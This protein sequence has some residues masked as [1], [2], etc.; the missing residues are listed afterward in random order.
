MNH[1]LA[2]LQTF[3][4]ND[5]ELT[6]QVRK[7]DITVWE[8]IESIPSGVDFPFVLLKNGGVESKEIFSYQKE[9]FLTARIYVV[10][11]TYRP[12]PDQIMDTNRGALVVAKHIVDLLEED[13]NHQFALVGFYTGS[14]PVQIHTI[15]GPFESEPFTPRGIT[16]G[17]TGKSTSRI[18]IDAR[19]YR[20]SI[21]EVQIA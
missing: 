21:R 16:T 5:Y 11:R 14:I 1:V 19:Y 6:Q 13:W 18:R 8:D 20:Y 15:A 4:R 9:E 3:L 10:N 2:G 7:S 17:T 12:A